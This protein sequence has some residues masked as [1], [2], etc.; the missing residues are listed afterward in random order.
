MRN[1]GW[2]RWLAAAAAGIAIFLLLA[3][4]R[5]GF[6]AESPEEM[7]LILCDALFVP[8]ALMTAFGLLLFASKGG[9]FDML[10]FGVQKALSVILP[11]KKREEMPKSFYDYK[12]EREAKGHARMGHILAVGIV[13]LVLAGLALMIYNRYEPVL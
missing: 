1:S 3:V 5:G 8:C 12:V 2:K 7:W 13:F 10:R 9:V 4:T 11:K 6:D